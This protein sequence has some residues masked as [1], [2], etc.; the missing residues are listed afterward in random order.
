MRTEA[1][2]RTA[3]KR[4]VVLVSGSGTNLGA[5][6]AACATGRLDAAVAA[7]VCNRADAYAL[8]RATDNDIPAL[9]LER[10]PG[11]ERADYDARLVDLVAPHEP[12]LVVLAGWM[13][14]LTPTFVGRFPVI[15]LHP[16]LPGQ[17]PG[18]H[19][20][21]E[22]FAAWQTGEV[23]ESGVMVHWVPD[24]GVDEGPVIVSEVVGFEPDDTRDSFAARVHAVEH[25]AIVEAIEL[26]LVAEL[27][28]PVAD[29]MLLASTEEE[30]HAPHQ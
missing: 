5:V 1:D 14:I 7:V 19:A 2:T 3:T 24:A 23:T 22:A 30:H 25:R 18:A 28:E 16:A 20:I 29:P 10:L 26:A 15:N 8:T 9:L 4:L 12:D 17:F 21:D 11:E 13:R 6:M 27:P